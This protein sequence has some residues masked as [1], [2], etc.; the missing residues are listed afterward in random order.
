MKE[1]LRIV[2]YYSEKAQDEVLSLPLWP[3]LAPQIQSTVVDHLLR[4]LSEALR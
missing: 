4:C 3:K 2:V 1:S